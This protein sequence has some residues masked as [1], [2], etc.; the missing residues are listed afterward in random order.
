M[1]KEIS[2]PTDNLPDVQPGLY[3]HYKGGIYSVLFTARHSETLERMVCYKSEIYGTHWSRPISEWHKPIDGT[4]RPRFKETKDSAWDAYSAE[5]DQI[6][7]TF[8][9][10]EEL[11]AVEYQKSLAEEQKNATQKCHSLVDECPT[12]CRE[13][14]FHAYWKNEF[15]YCHCCKLKWRIGYNNQTPF[16][17]KNEKDWKSTALFFLATKDY[18]EVPAED[19]V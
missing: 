16:W 17:P 14:R 11:E 1:N 7:K 3:L 13:S 12:C 9:P 4:D 8:G 10:A 5:V 6:L 2:H 18:K 15:G 19:L